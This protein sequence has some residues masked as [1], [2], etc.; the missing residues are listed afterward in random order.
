MTSKVVRWLLT[1]AASAGVVGTGVAAAKGG[2]KTAKKDL[3]G[4]DRK[5]KIIEVL[6]DYIPAGIWGACT[7]GCIF[8]NTI[9]SDVVEKNMYGAILAAQTAYL[10]YKDKAK[11]VM[12][13]DQM[14]VLR[15][16]QRQNA[17]RA[18]ENLKDDEI[19]CY[20]PYLEY[21]A[22]GGYFG[23]TY[24][25]FLMAKYL[26]NED[27]AINGVAHHSDFYKYLN[28]APTAA[29][30]TMGWSYGAGTIYRYSWINVEE[31]KFTLDDGLEV[32]EIKYY[33]KPTSDYLSF[34]H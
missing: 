19:L 31:E 9:V 3:R 5:S 6:P 1:L 2:M 11:S 25:D 13:E 23:C 24:Y 17:Y 34:G 7:I 28:V 16:K 21:T 15:Q 4:L 29:S 12:T 20:D 14:Q 30:D 18:L 32:C 10:G 22:C 27:L 26:I 33:S 8:A